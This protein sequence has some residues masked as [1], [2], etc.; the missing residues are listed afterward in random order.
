MR[1][2]AV[3]L[4]VRTVQEFGADDATHMA[5]GVAYYAILSLFPLLT[6][7]VAV[8]GVFLSS[9]RIKLEVIDFFAQ[10][11]PG[12]KDVFEEYVVEQ[13]S[14]WGV[15][16]GVVALIGLFWSASAMFG[17]IGRAVNRAWDVHQDRPFYIRKLRDLGMA[18]GTG[19]LFLVSVGATSLFSVMESFDVP[20]AGT[21]AQV[22][23]RVFAFVVS[24]SVFLIIYKFVPNTKTHW[25]YI[26]PGALLAAVFFEAGK[27]LFVLYL[28]RFADYG[29]TYGNL[30]SVIALL[31]WI[32]ISALILIVGAEF[33]SEYGR[34][35]RGGS[36]GVLMA[37]EPGRPDIGDEA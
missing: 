7:L 9:E 4:V 2:P 6:A 21:A 26:W 24:L 29:S 31:I 15:A 33:S 8:L 3:E 37:A 11:L 22:G 14:D 23:A 34:M 18:L 12:L 36:R 5:A 13:V 35:R 27:S 20:L 32:F 30:G 1:I 19:L 17:A 25:R 10:N 28:D 16:L